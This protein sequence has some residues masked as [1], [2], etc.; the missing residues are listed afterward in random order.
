MHK[1]VRT[2]NQIGSS[3][4][5]DIFIFFSYSKIYIESRDIR[6]IVVNEKG[7]LAEFHYRISFSLTYLCQKVYIRIL[8]RGFSNNYFIVGLNESHRS[9]HASLYDLRVNV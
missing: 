8:S 3:N 9:L 5:G 2:I 4:E 7:R 6:K 1:S